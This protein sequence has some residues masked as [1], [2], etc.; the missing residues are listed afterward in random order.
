MKTLRWD[1]GDNE[2][3]AH[4]TCRLRR[5]D[6]GRL[7]AVGQRTFDRV[8]PRWL[9]RSP[10][11]ASRGRDPCR[12]VHSRPH[13]SSWARRERTYRRDH[14]IEREFEDVAAVVRGLQPPVTL[15]GHSSSAWY[16]LYGA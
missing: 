2:V 10:D 12:A 4:G 5:W 9:R 11:M 14:V 1:T 15:V 7:R 13:R 16:V 6:A 8:G 3:D